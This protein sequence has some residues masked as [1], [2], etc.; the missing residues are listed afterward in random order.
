VVDDEDVVRNFVETVLARHGF[1]TVS[2]AGPAEA[3]ERLDS[4]PRIDLLLTDVRMPAMNGVHLAREII[5]RRPATPVVFMSGSCDDEYRSLTSEPLLAKPFRIPQLLERVE[6]ALSQVT[7]RS[8]A[9]G[10]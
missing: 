6:I 9:I 10:A 4:V 8:D 3:L 5:R 7:D 1:Q 2:A